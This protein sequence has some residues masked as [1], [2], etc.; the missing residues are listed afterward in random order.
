MLTLQLQILHS[1][2]KAATEYADLNSDLLQ[3]YEPPTGSGKSWY[4][5]PTENTFSATW[6]FA[7]TPTNYALSPLFAFAM[8]GPFSM[9]RQTSGQDFL[10][11]APVAM[12]DF[13]ANAWG[14]ANP[15]PS[16]AQPSTQMWPW[17]LAGT[18]NTATTPGYGIIK[19]SITF[20]DNTEIKFSFPGPSA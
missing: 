15:A 20:P 4:R 19:M 7:A 12:M 1:L 11:S 14:I 8:L 5:P 2:T 16:S 9:Q 10:F 6:P 18:S 13:W 17:G 3:G